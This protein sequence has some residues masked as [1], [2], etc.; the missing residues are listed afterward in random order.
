M[1]LVDYDRT[2]H[3]TYEQG[4]TLSTDT[5]IQWMDVLSSYLSEQTCLRVLDIGSGTGRFSLPIAEA[6]SAWVIGIEPSE[7]MRCKATTA[8]RAGHISYVG[9]KAEDIPFVDG[10]VDAVFASM[11]IHHFADIAQAG[12]EIARVL[13]PHGQVFIRNSFKDRLDSVRY[14]D[15]FPSARHID[16]SRLPSIEIVVDIFRGI[17]LLFEDHRVVRQCIDD[18]LTAHYERIKLKA[19]ST[20]EFISDEE[21]Q[22]G[23]RRMEEEAR[24]E[25]P[26][27]PV[28]EDIDLLVFKKTISRD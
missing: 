5:V 11:V 3:K 27:R 21:F 4:R 8:S 15:F 26:P 9:G 1:R 2:L 12:R 6:F 24:N 22:S 16:N 10:C 25:I 28:W 23:I 7:G 14:Y 20:F 17:G 19:L 13:R 18:S